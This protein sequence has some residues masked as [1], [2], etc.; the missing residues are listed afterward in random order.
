MKSL[1]KYNLQFHNIQGKTWLRNNLYYII[2][3]IFLLVENM[4][5]QLR[6]YSH[7]LNTDRKFEF[8]KMLFP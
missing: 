6:E 5:G 4:R 3:L 1:N 7:I 2:R 8:F